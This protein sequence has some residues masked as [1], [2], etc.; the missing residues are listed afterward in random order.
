MKSSRKK[1]K[2]YSVFPVKIFINFLG[3]GSS[4]KSEFFMSC[5]FI[6][7]LGNKTCNKV[8]LPKVGQLLSQLLCGFLGGSPYTWSF[9]PRILGFA[10]LFPVLLS[11]KTSQL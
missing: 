9:V 3:A 5:N 11:P 4:P 7:V 1:T 10:G 6:K 8:M 2:V